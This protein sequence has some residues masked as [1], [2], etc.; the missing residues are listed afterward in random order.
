[1]LANNSLITVNPFEGLKVIEKKKNISEGRKA[2]TPLQL[3]ELFK[4]ADSYGRGDRRYWLIIIGRYTGA[5]MNEICQLKPEGI[6]EDVIHIRGDF[7]KMANSK[8]SIPTHPKLI[9]LGIL[10][11]VN[12]CMRSRLFH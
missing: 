3:K 7:L 5:R 9:E 11:W 12:E 1:M 10:D 8:R 2:Y 6:T 4:L